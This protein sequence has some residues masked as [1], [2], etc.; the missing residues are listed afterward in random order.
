MKRILLFLIVLAAGAYGF[1]MKTEIG[2][3]VLL[4]R[5]AR[6]AYAAAPDLGDGLH[7]FVCGSASPLPAPG[8]AQGCIAVVTP[9]HYFVV[10][11][12]SGS[13]NNLG[14]GQLPA[15]RLS[16]VLLT[17]FHSDHIVD[18]PSINLTSW[19]A[20]RKE[21]L[22]VFGPEGVAQVVDGFN[23]ALAQD[24]VYR[25]RHHGR[26]FMPAEAGLLR[27]VPIAMDEAMAFGDLTITAFPANHEP[28]SPAVSYRFDY[29]GRSVVVTGDTVVTQRLEEMT[30]RADLLLTDA[31]SLPVVSALAAAAAESGQTRLAKILVDIQDYHASTTD[32]AALATASGVGMTALYHMVPAPRNRLLENV[33][34][35]DLPEA[36]VLTEDR[37]WFSLPAASDEIELR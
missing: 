9:D 13:G 34:A 16:G 36:T 37:M 30:A 22:R 6:A 7:V 11:A 24:R 32:V 14:L 2:Q 28:V 29:R 20:G 4:E 35:R 23:A 18:L 8:R 5:G 25:T 17:H 10:D 26:D 27:A 33:F 3:N 15:E 19:A 1:F 12:G 31:L 21:A